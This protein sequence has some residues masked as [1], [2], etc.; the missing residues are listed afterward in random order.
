MSLR[1]PSLVLAISRSAMSFLRASSSFS[2]YFA[3]KILQPRSDTIAGHSASTFASSSSSVICNTPRAT[4]ALHTSASRWAETQRHRAARIT[5]KANLEKKAERG[6]IRDE[7]KPHVVLGTRPGD[8]EKWRSCDLARILVTPEE[9]NGTVWT[10]M[11]E[12]KEIKLPMVM[13]YGLEGTDAAGTKDEKI[14]LFFKDLPQASVNNSM[15]TKTVD[16]HARFS[17]NVEK[18]AEFQN[19]ANIEYKKSTSFARV[20]DLRNANARGIAFE[21]R[22]RIIAAF[23]PSGS[24]SDSGYPEVQGASLFL[25]I[26]CTDSLTFLSALPNFSCFINHED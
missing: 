19:L 21:N 3:S 2:A 5:R 25:A 15:P 22:R 1:A 12:E 10:K 8:E 13:S 4:A 14:E 9:L 20:I 18:S 24:M 11:E 26:S 23:S 17:L 16:H 7:T 6:R